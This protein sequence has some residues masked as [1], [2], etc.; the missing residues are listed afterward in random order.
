MKTTSHRALP[1]LIMLFNETSINLTADMTIDA[2]S[3]ALG[4]SSLH[5]SVIRAK[6][7]DHEL[8]HGGSE[9]LWVSMALDPSNLSVTAERRKFDVGLH[10]QQ[11]CIHSPYAVFGSVRRNES[12]LFHVFLKRSLLAEVLGDLCDGD[13]N[14]IEVGS[15]FG[16][17]D[18]DM[19]ELL[20]VIHHALHRPSTQGRL[21][22]E[23]VTR[24]LAVDIFE[25]HLPLPRR[26]KEKI[27]A[28]R[29]GTRQIRD[30]VDHIREH[31]ASDIMLTDLATLSG[32]C[33]TTFIQQFKTTFGESPYQYIIRRRIY[34]AQELL[35]NS[36]HSIAHIAALCGF[37]DQ[38]HFSRYFQKIVGVPPS[39]YRRGEVVGLA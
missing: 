23:H 24:A 9:D 8:T 35:M 38:A 33:Y 5:A 29:L 15:K 22:M 34:R 3:D 32:L 14:A 19:A 2:S 12:S 20:Q 25:R 4:W 21:K 27:F 30:V 39:V 26:Q 10:Y 37:F 31:L 6:P 28:R 16:V 11:I 7:Y 17:D 1:H 13:V 18:P 36:P